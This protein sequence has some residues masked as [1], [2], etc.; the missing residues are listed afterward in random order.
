MEKK[1]LT[2]EVVGKQVI[3]SK[4]II[5]GNV[6][7]V[8]FD[9]DS[10]NVD[11]VVVTKTGADI[12]VEGNSIIILGDVVLLNKPIELPASKVEEIPEVEKPQVT[13]EPS[14]A[15]TGLCSVCEYQND[16][17]SNFCIKCGAKL[18]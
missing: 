4:A 1:Y 10:K 13:T 6:K 12:I 7:D 2:K 14:S 17:E 16:V 15:T 11:L 8:S 3:D 9:M 18:K 5:V